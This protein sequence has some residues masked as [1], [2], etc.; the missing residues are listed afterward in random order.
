LSECGDY[1]APFYGSDINSPLG[2]TLEV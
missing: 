2:M 1:F